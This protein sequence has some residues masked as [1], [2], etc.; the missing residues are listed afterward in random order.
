MRWILLTLLLAG[1]FLYASCPDAKYLPSGYTT[2]MR[3][4]FR[5]IGIYLERNGIDP[6]DLRFF[7]QPGSAD[8]EKWFKDLQ[9]TDVESV[10]VLTREREKDLIAL[11]CFRR[12]RS[13]HALQGKLP[14][15]EV[16]VFWPGG[17]AERKQG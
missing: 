16:P 12:C 8:G 13:S 14:R 5:K 4:D 6:Q 11:V 1:S 10:L 3:I 7:Q 9:Y 2:G 15:K 17:T